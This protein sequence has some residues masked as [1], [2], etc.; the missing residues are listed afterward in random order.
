V[1]WFGFTTWHGKAAVR[2]S[3]SG[4]ST[5]PED[6]DRTVAAT[7]AAYRQRLDGRAGPSALG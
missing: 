3:V 1:A 4:W 7:I 6:V 2:L 5:G